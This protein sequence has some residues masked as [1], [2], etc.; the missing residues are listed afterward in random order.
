[1]LIYG[2]YDATRD[3]RAIEED[4]TRHNATCRS[5]I[6][7]TYVYYMVKFTIIFYSHASVRE[8]SADKRE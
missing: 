3:D 7:N 8:N 2:S 5:E 1:M 6:R 4:A